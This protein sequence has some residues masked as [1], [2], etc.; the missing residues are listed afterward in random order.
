M[1]VGSLTIL[2]LKILN[3]N[4]YLFY[5]LSGGARGQKMNTFRYDEM[6]DT[7]GIITKPYHLGGR[8]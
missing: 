7:L 1:G 6:V 2:G 8:F 5:F 4:V 3:L